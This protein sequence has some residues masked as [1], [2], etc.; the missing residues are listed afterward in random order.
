MPLSKR[1]CKNDHNVAYKKLTQEQIS[2]IKAFTYI[3]S[4]KFPIQEH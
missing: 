2:I 3:M 4:K 1:R